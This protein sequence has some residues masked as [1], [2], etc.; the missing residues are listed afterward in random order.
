MGQREG[1]KS[2]WAKLKD[3][4]KGRVAEEK[5]TFEDE[6]RRLRAMVEKLQKE[7]GR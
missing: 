6:V 2:L 4:A 5:K 7:K 1:S 3:E